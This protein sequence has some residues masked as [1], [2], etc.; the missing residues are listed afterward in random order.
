M[1]AIFSLAPLHKALLGFAITI[2]SLVIAAGWMLWK[3]R[4]P[5]LAVFF[6]M[7][8]LGIVLF[9]LGAAS[10]KNALF[11]DFFWHGSRS[12]GAVALTFD[13]GP[14]PVYTPEVLSI[15]D[16][17]HA[18]ATFFMLGK[19]VRLYPEVARSVA[20]NGHAVG[21]HCYNHGSLL[22]ASRGKVRSEI[23][24]AE[25]AFVE[26]LGQ[27]PR[28]LRAPF[29]FHPPFVVREASQ[30]GY[31]LVGWSVSPHD[32]SHL[33]PEILVRRALARVR[34]GDI[35]LLHD[36]GGD[37]QATVEALPA[38]LEGLRQKGLRCVSL[39]ELMGESA[40]GRPESKPFSPRLADEAGTPNAAKAARSSW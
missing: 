11:G 32:S 25:A 7:V 23:V 18:K 30:R 40:A 13:D 29:G 21:S 10:P 28:F 26:T 5:A 15:L 3:S 37:R 36:G 8:A 4:R 14:H 1:N 16:R 12:L 34:P 35:L 31:L 27:R 22:L 33:P 2:I 39:S 9:G 20:A 24:E 6:A 17:Y 19:R 38:I